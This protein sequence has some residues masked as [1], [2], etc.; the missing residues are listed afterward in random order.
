[1]NRRR[2]A[3]RRLSVDHI[4]CTA[5]GLCAGL[6]PELVELDEWGYPIV[7]GEPVPDTL[8]PTARAAVAACPRLALRLGS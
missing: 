2:T 1:M 8:I 7:A 6:L 3:P 4:A 5:E